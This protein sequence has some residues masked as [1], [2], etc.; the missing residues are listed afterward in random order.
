[1]FIGSMGNALRNGDSGSGSTQQIAGHGGRR[2][3]SL[4]IDSQSEE[5]VEELAPKRKKIVTTSTY[6]YETLFRKGI[7]SDI[8]ITALG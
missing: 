6:I 8:T 2:K 3:R 7:N 1:M 5:E 4:E